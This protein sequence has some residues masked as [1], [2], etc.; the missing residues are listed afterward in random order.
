MNAVLK[1]IPAAGP[2]RMRILKELAE[3]AAKDGDRLIYPTHYFELEGEPVGFVSLGAVPFVTL[4][5]DSAAMSS[6]RSVRA[7]DHYE[8]ILRNAGATHYLV[9]CTAGSPFH[10][11]MDR[12]G[13]RFICD[14]SLYSK[15]L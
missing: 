2:E 6:V 11:V 13:C 1:P 5:F 14:T 3:R 10:S 4:W 12:F 15:E 8:V 9:N 7:V